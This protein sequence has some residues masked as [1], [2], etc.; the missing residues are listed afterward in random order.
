MVKKK[1]PR[2]KKIKCNYFGIEIS[3]KN[4]MIRSL[5]DTNFFPI[6]F[7]INLTNILLEN[8]NICKLTAVNETTVAHYKHLKLISDFFALR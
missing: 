8:E 3:S 5:K 4:E 7:H 6:Q 1:S 2:T